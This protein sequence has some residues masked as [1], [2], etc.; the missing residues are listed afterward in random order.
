MGGAVK[1]PVSLAKEVRDFGKRYGLRCPIPSEKKTLDNIYSLY[2]SPSDRVDSALGHREIDVDDDLEKANRIKKRYESKGYHV[3]MQS[4]IADAS[5]NMTAELFS[6]KY[7]VVAVLLHEGTHR[8]N[9]KIN[10]FMSE[11]VA[12]V[13]GFN[14]AMQF[15]KERG[16]KR[17]LRETYDNLCARE[18]EAKLFQRNYS[19]RTAAFR[20]GKRIDSHRGK[21]NAEL[22][23]EMY[24]YSDFPLVSLAYDVIGDFGKATDLFLKLPSQRDA[25][26]Q[27]LE[28][29]I[30]DSFEKK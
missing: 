13:I 26:T 21:N 25:C 10:S 1:D 28:K 24:Y 23:F 4:T 5:G 2:I 9:Q 12:D 30:T 29:V 20:E 19:R 15:F 16:D 22:L 8:A 11:P 7:Y 3:Y 27:M 6:D 17:G 18:H 14:G